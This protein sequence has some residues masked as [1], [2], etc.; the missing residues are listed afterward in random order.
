M[1]SE[2]AV[3]FRHLMC[4]LNDDRAIR[5][6]LDSRR[7]SYAP[8]NIPALPNRSNGG[9]QVSDGPS[10]MPAVIAVCLAQERHGLRE[11]RYGRGQLLIGENLQLTVVRYRAVSLPLMRPPMLL[12][13]AFRL[14]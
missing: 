7:T 11:H 4:H 8:P 12:G 9:P 1:N 3:L 2:K 13:F 14:R 10:P 6:R 5:E